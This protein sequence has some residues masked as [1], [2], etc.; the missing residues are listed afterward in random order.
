M[1]FGAESRNKWRA[2]SEILI[3]AGALE[4][5]RVL[6]LEDEYLIAMD[7]EQLCRDHGATEVTIHRDLDGIDVP[8][9]ASFDAAIIDVMLQGR[10]TLDFARGLRERNIP[11]VFASGYSHFDDI[12]AAFP[13]VRVVAKPYAGVDLIGA[14][15][16]ARARQLSGG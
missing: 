3:L 11:F 10:S 12:F 6:I 15:S 4:G 1:T 2:Y 13:G 7:V 14:L 16:E 5:L 9:A 8:V